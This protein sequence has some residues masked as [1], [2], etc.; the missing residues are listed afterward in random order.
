MTDHCNVAKQP[1]NKASNRYRNVLPCQYISTLVYIIATSSNS[2]VHASD[3]G[4]YRP[5]ASQA[6]RFY[7][8]LVRL[9]LSN[10]IFQ[11]SLL[12]DLFI[13]KHRSAAVR[14]LWR[15]RNVCCR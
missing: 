10:G 5:G 13:L 2:A 8:V 9:D 15:N 4:K 12:Y 7:R 11:L 6:H 1:E 3:L 14:V